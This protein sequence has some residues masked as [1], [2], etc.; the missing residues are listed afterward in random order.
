EARQRANAT[1]SPGPA[2]VQTPPLAGASAAAASA[3]APAAIA[4][5]APPPAAVAERAE[6]DV[7]KEA[8]ADSPAAPLAARRQAFA[9]YQIGSPDGSV[10]WR[11]VNGQQVERSTDG[12]TSW[13]PATISSPDRLIAGASPS[14]TVSWFVGSR[15]A[16]YLTTDGT[17]FMRLPFT[18]MVDLTAVFA[19]DALVAT[20]SSADGRSWRT[21]DGGKTWLMVR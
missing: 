9:P 2:D 12:G 16:V 3:A 7:K 18:E 5:A 1:A 19:T 13:T 4:P 10:R 6:A 11:L 17:R 8:A 20:V 15:G 21:S 14:A